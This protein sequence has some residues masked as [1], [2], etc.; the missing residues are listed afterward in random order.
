M[1]LIIERT[2]WETVGREG[3]T[4]VPEMV[5]AMTD[6]AACNSD[7]LSDCVHKYLPYPGHARCSECGMGEKQGHVATCSKIQRWTPQTARQ[8]VGE[9]FRS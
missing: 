3:E 9:T 5:Q 8:R 1:H 4:F 6:C 2:G 7:G